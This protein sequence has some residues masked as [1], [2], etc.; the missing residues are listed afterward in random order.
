MRIA[1]KSFPTHFSFHS[2]AESTVHLEFQLGHLNFF[3]AKSFNLFDVLSKR[4][5]VILV[6]NDC[7]L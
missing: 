3:N 2:Y 1:Q 7:L 6:A 4:V 5:S